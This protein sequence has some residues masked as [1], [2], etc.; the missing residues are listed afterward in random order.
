MVKFRPP[1]ARLSAPEKRYRVRELL[2]TKVIKPMIREKVQ[3]RKSGTSQWTASQEIRLVN[4]TRD[5]M[6]EQLRS[7]PSREISDAVS[8]G[9]TGDELE[10]WQL[11]LA[12]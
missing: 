1:N 6:V 3:K 4:E 9:F 5:S 7:F 10:K 2:A 12:N 8:E 11:T